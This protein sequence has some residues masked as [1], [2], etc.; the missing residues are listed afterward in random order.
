MKSLENAHTFP[1]ASEPMKL[2]ASL[3]PLFK[4]GL[5]ALGRK[6]HGSLTKLD[7]SL[8]RTDCISTIWRPRTRQKVPLL[9]ATAFLKVLL[10]SVHSPPH[11]EKDEFDGLGVFFRSKSDI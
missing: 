4:S 7:S 8:W 11:A 1:N 6:A 10:S 3:V 9:R 2:P 5:M